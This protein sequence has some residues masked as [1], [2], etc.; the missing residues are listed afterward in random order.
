MKNRALATSLVVFLL[1]AAMAIGGCSKSSVKQNPPDQNQTAQNPV[2]ENNYTT[3][4][5]SLYFADNQANY[6]I[7]ETREVKILK[8]AGSEAIAGA[9]VNELIA[10]PADKSLYATIP[11][12][13]K[14]LSVKI[15]G[16]TAIVDF[17]EEIQTRHPGGSSGESMTLNSIVNSLTEIQGIKQVQILINGKKVES[18]AGHADLTQPLSRNESIIKK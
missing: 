1:F 17:S 12:E 2:A 10:G 16:Q 3:A 5:L 14:L 8:N 6:L 18:L 13:A 15:D 4:P 7:R 9:V 11:K